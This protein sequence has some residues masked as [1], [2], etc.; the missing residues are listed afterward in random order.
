MSMVL[1]KLQSILFVAMATLAAFEP[2]MGQVSV[3]TYHNDNSRSGLN[4]FETIL[5]SGNV[6]SS[7]FGKVFFFT[8]DGRV[9]A[10]PLYVR[11]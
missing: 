2:A 4:P 6:N 3:L 10:Q 9:D 11:A 1:G 7:K 8:T 5:T